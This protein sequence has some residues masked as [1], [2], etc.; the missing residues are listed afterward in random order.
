MN[1]T[2][3][4]RI[5]FLYSE[6]ADY[7]LA[8]VQA[9]VEDEHTSTVRI[10]HWDVNPEAPFD[11]SDHQ[12]LNL[13]AKGSYKNRP[14]LIKSVIEFKPTCIV[15]SGWMDADYMSVAKKYQPNIPVVLTL[16]NWWTGSMKQWMAAATSAF[17]L[18]RHF[19]KAWVPGEKQV[20]F[21]LKLGFK[22]EDIAKGFYCADDR[23]FEAVYQARK[24]ST[25]FKPTRK[26]LYVG[27]YIEV[28]GIQELWSAFV[29]LSPQFPR[30]ELHCIGTGELW[31]NREIHPKIFHHGFVQPSQLHE[32]L[33]EADA[34]VMPS[35]K[36]PWGVVLHEMALAGIPLLATKEVGASE[37]FLDHEKNG[38][39]VH[40]S[41]LGNALKDI[42]DSSTSRF[43]KFGDHSRC[44][45]ETSLPR[46]W[47][48][49]LFSIA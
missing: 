47:V 34:F 29:Q 46:H 3:S 44:L 17:Y 9:L 25:G 10:I 41:Q 30:W 33:V 42:F 19:N 12:N 18:R 11:L 8:C 13:I 15:V 7:F 45:G 5:L 31:N 48:H 32:H 26:L 20:N 14:E 1:D 28:K 40:P 23:K 21:A 36:E 4:H 43:S 39:L 35:K 49:T 38:L 24:K 37:K 2:A 22:S 16:D 6:L 27:R